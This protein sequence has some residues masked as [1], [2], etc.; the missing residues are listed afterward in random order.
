M[1]QTGDAPQNLAYP[2]CFD[3]ISVYN[4]VE[5]MSI[6]FAPS[7]NIC[8]LKRL[9]LYLHVFKLKIDLFYKQVEF[10]LFLS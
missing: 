5:N 4:Y 10:L 8:S 7:P 3:S 9:Q 6:Y 2:L 1:D